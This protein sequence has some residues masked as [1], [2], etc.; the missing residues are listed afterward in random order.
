MKPFMMKPFTR[1]RVSAG[2]TGPRY[3]RTSDRMPVSSLRED[4]QLKVLSLSSQRYS[5][6]VDLMR[7]RWNPSLHITEILNN[8]MKK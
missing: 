1:K 8:A 4:L 7:I 5:T 6:L 2:T 3:C